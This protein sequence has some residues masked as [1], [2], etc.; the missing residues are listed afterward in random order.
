MSGQA[1]PHADERELL[2]AFIAQ[3]RDGVRYAAFGLT[4]EQ[5]RVTP[6]ASA[7]SI[8]GLVVHV[9][10]MERGWMDTVLQREGAGTDEDSYESGFRLDADQTLAEALADLDAVAAETATIV[11]GM[12]LDAPVPVPQDVPWFP[13]DI[14]AW[15]LRWVL[16][17][18][19]EEIGRHA[20]HADIIRESIDGANMYE[21]MA[22]VEG[23]P[24]TEWIQPWTPAEDSAS[25]N[26]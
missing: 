21:L 15:S 23:W 17:H 2:L 14:D 7:L 3:Q 4:D 13:D 8:G 10:Q 26:G 11:G 20:G 25:V 5:A 12:S 19:I 6:T 16:L 24:A 22:G 1:P 18:L 9:T